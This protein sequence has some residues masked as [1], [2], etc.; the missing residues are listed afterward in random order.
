MKN[1]NNIEDLKKIVSQVAQGKI[2]KKIRAPKYKNAQ[3]A[4]VVVANSTKNII[5]LKNSVDELPMIQ[6]S[7]T[8]FYTNL[9]KHALDHYAVF[10]EMNIPEDVGLAALKNNPDIKK[11]YQNAVNYINTKSFSQIVKESMVGNVPSAKMVIAYIAT[12]YPD[13]LAEDPMFEKKKKED[14]PEG[15][16]EESWFDKESG[17]VSKSEP[18]VPPSIGIKLEAGSAIEYDPQLDS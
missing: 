9:K 4:Y 1:D 13:N 16:T 12:N 14:T 10:E 3:D 17:K 15:D 11:V 8:E 18:V 6:V 2:I 7:L 5:F